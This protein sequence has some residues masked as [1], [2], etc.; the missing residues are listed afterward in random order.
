MPATSELI[1]SNRTNEEVAKEINADWLIYQTLEDLIETTQS[2]NPDITEFETSIFTGE[3]I[4]PLDEN[5]L[6]DLENTRKDE[7]KIQREKSKANG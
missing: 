7:L 4:T 1:A 5:Y 2:G 6:E 3:Y